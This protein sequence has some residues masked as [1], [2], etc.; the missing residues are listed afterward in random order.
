MP[1]LFP[2]LIY[3]PVARPPERLERLS[4]AQVRALA[5]QQLKQL[6]RQGQQPKTNCTAPFIHPVG[7]E[8]TSLRFLHDYPHK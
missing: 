1:N 2:L 4:K 5:M 8:D 7:G 3:R 6:K